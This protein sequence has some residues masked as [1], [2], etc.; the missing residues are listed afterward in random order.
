MEERESDMGMGEEEN[1]RLYFYLKCYPSFMW[2][3]SDPYFGK[4]VIE[5]KSDDG[6]NSDEGESDVGSVKIGWKW[7]MKD[8]K[9]K[10]PSRE[11]RRL[12]SG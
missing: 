5:G 9:G 1:A 3:R 4:N 11:E 2:D 7:K 6:D 8:R 10:S 12:W